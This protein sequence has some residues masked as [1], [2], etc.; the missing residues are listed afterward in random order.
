M[1]APILALAASFVLALAL[2]PL[3][4]RL[5][6]RV[7]ALDHPLTARKQHRRAVPRIGGLAIA[8][9]FLGGIGFASLAGGA[10]IHG[11]RI[12]VISLA[13]LLVVAAGAVDDVRG[14]SPRV[15]LAAQV[16]AAALV[17]AGGLRIEAVANP[18][19]APLPLGDLSLPF[20]LLF[21]VGAMN[22]MN[23]IDG[24]D[25]LAGGIAAVAAAAVIAVG[26]RRGDPVLAV[27]GA[28]V[29]GACLG[30]L[31]HNLRPASIFMGDGGSLFL[32]LVLSASSIPGAGEG[33][34][35]TD[36]LAP[37]VALGV[38]VVDTAMALVRR[39]ARGSPISWGDRE[40]LH[41]RLVALG[42][43]PRRAMEVLIAAGAVHAGFAVAIAG[44][45]GARAA[46]LLAG[47]ALLDLAGLRAIGYFRP[48]LLGRLAAERRRYTALRSAVRAASS[49]LEDASSMAEVQAVL[50]GTAPAIGASRARLLLSGGPRVHGPYTRTRHG[51]RGERPG[52]GSIE[53]RW[54]PERSRLDRSTEMA[55]EMLCARVEVAVR[56]LGAG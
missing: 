8:A 52:G 7:G 50:D 46:L 14:L 24:L 27:S 42:F 18:L 51:L 15:K 12:A 54:S 10:A 19:G 36:L 26:L 4:G 47:I 22:A 29:A 40:H 30:F 56:R 28:A 44:S 34:R 17:W 21:L 38:P 35:G 6:H 37:V 31:R 25:G 41:H 16:A 53:F 48:G 49:Q 1:L 23:L 3:A 45:S 20:T 33:A 55:A 9:A 11:R 13:G 43:T 2:T 5:A 39:M 32:G